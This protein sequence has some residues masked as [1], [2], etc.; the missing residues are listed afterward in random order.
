MLGFRKNRTSAEKDK[1]EK[2]GLFSRL[3]ESLSRTRQSLTGG[4]ADLVLG[5]KSIDGALLEEI[6]TMLLM[7]DVGVDA[8]RE[9]IDKLTQ[10]VA[11]KELGNAETL[12][13]ALHDHM[14]TIL[15]PVSQP[16][17]A[18]ES[19][20]PFVILMVGINGAGKPRPSAN[21][22]TASS[23]TESG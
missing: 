19:T 22:H 6:E 23:R 7:A 8:T 16:L 2:S 13:A 12:M 18:A 15:E 20:S 9:I 17:R 3:K 21:L 14:Q 10:Q 1:P 5:S 11:R 4:V